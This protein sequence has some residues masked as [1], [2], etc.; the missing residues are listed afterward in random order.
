MCTFFVVT[1]IQSTQTQF[2]YW[3]QKK[4][5]SQW[6]LLWS[7]VLLFTFSLLLIWSYF[8]WEA[9][10]DY[11]EFNWFLYN[12]SGEWTDGTVP[13][14][15]TTAAGFTYIAFLMV[16]ALCHVALGQQLNLHWLHKVTCQQSEI[17]CVCVT[18]RCKGVDEFCIC[19]SEL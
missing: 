17:V 2:W 9:D 3:E 8:W 14:L 1:V 18:V 4:Q 13:I 6:E 16:L 15:A 5:A 19:L 7:L 11:N 10:N 12:N